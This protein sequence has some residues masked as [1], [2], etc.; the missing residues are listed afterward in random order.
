MN[1][2]VMQCEQRERERL[3]RREKTE[4]CRDLGREKERVRASLTAAAIYS[5]DLLHSP[6]M[7]SHLPRID[8]QNSLCTLTLTH[9]LTK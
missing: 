2:A 7:L 6:E 9:D 5:Q 4:R 1:A 3:S 8:R